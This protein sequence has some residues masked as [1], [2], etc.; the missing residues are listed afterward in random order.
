MTRIRVL[1]V[2]DSVVF[3]RM[4]KEA[5]SQDPELEVVGLAA[6]GRIALNLIEQCTPDVVTLDL[7]MPDGDGLEVLR[8]LQPRLARLP[9]IM[10]S[11][12]TE[13]GAAATLDALALGAR[14]YVTKP[15]NGG[16]EAST[17][18]IRDELIPKIKALSG[19]S[20]GIELRPQIPRA[21]IPGIT[22]AASP[23]IRT[24]I[25]LVAIGT[26]TGGPNALTAVLPQFPRQF[27][28]AMAVVQ[29]MPPTFTRFL[30]ERLN[31]ACELQ[32]VEAA[33]DQVVKPG[34]I[35]IAPGDFHM[36]VENEGTQVHLRAF[37]TPP[38]NSCR[39]SV[40][41]LF[42]SVAR[43]YGP[44]ALAVVMTGMGQDGLRGCEQLHETGAAI[45]AQ[46]EA[47][48]VVWGMPGFVVNAGLAS[49]VVPLSQIAAEIIRRVQQSHTSSATQESRTHVY[50]SR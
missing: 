19:L 4:L 28:A 10:F 17:A 33:H 49:K 37:R 15:C 47:S 42:R 27:P 48:S 45:L 3:R 18:R 1:V 14:D 20:R 40:D 46:D 25:E 7:E 41:V 44:R 29:H 32:V 16:A 24:P 38:E 2:D 12:L 34:S 21:A 36:A 50:Q 39:P 13:R 43:T 26:S 5:L 9:V 22:R 35:W 11:T 23:G 8:Q 6:N 30:A 31:T